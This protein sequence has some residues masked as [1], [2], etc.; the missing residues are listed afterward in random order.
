MSEATCF[1]NDDVAFAKTPV[2]HDLHC[3]F[4]MLLSQRHEVRVDSQISPGNCGVVTWSRNRR[5]SH[6]PNILGKTEPHELCLG[7]LGVELD[8]VANWFDLA[9]GHE[10]PKKL[11]V[12]V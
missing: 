9:V 8:L 2:K 7:A 5:I 1:W 6:W 12:K 4:T 3:G 10:V 11:G